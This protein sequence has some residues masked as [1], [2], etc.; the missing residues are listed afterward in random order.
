LLILKNTFSINPEVN[1]PTPKGKYKGTHYG[2]I[3]IRSTG[4]C[5]IKDLKGNRIAQ[6]VDS[7]YCTVLQRFDGYSYFIEKRT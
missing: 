3:A 4:R 5:D 7:K 2:S 6:G 1:Y